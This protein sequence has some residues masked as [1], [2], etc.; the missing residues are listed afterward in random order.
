MELIDRL[1]TIKALDEAKIRT[2]S[3][4]YDRILDVIG[5]MPTI[6][7]RK[8]GKWILTKRN[9]ILC[10]VCY[11]GFRRMPTLFG[12]PMFNFCPLCGAKME[13]EEKDLEF[14][15]EECIVSRRVNEEKDCDI[16]FKII[17][18]EEG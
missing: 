18:K 14:A 8:T 13:G 11:S 15:G 12:K 7:E 17:K 6:E 4:E 2:T 16:A 10:G 3:E 1:K 5:S 9:G